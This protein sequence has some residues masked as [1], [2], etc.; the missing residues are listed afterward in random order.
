L[1]KILVAQHERH[2]S[3]LALGREPFAN[4][5]GLLEINVPGVCVASSVLERESEDGAALLDG[6]FAVGFGGGEG[7]RDFVESRRGGERF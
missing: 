1:S 4:R 5:T 6:V 7:A 2:S 3:F